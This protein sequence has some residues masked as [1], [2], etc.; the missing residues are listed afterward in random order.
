MSDDEEKTY[1]FSEL[2]WT[3]SPRVFASE[4]V[5]QSRIDGLSMVLIEGER[6]DE[7]V[8]ALTIPAARRLARRIRRAIAKTE[9]R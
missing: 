1:T 8:F 3:D 2:I 5:D 9:G 6:E 4:V 7:V